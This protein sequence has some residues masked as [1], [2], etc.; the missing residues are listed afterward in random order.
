[1]DIL[2]RTL[3]KSQELWQNQDIVNQTH[4]L[5]IDQTQKY[6]DHLKYLTKE[7]NH[8]QQLLDEKLSIPPE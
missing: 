2:T 8:R 6:I 4:S 5:G 3:A 7:L 1:M